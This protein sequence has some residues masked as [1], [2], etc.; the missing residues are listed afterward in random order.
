MG[1][2]SRSALGSGASQCYPAW[3][4]LSTNSL[5]GGAIMPV[6]T[7]IEPFKIKTVEPIRWTIK[8]KSADCADDADES[9]LVLICVIGGICGV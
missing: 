2:L 4:K 1:I 7:I 6:R 5:S 9:R 3:V 8:D